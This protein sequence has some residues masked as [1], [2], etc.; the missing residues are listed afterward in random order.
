M[1]EVI[2]YEGQNY[3]EVDIKGLKR[4]LPVVEVSPGIFIASDA[5]LILGDIE[6]IEKVAEALSNKIMQFSPSIVITPEA[7]AI[8]L[9]YEVSRNLRHKKFIVAR[10]S[11]KAYMKKYLVEPVS[12]ITTT[13]EQK[14]ILTEEDIKLIKG[15]RTCIIDDVVST[16]GTIKALENLVQRAEGEVVCKAT[17]WKEGPWYNDTDLVFLSRLPVFVTPKNLKAIKEGGI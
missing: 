14:L 7:K 5:E 17:I 16:G 1:E 8:A 6:F 10:K 15:K 11:L 3:Y 13:E 4:S 2:V 12:S 9:A